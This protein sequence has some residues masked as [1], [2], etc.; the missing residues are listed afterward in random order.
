MAPVSTARIGAKI[1]VVPTAVAMEFSHE[2]LCL[3]PSTS[4]SVMCTLSV[5]ELYSVAVA[6]E[7][8]FARLGCASNILGV[9]S[10][11]S[12]VQEET[13][14]MTPHLLPDPNRFTKL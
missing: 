8:T 2:A 13:S 3:K 5:I 10:R 14:R 9:C 1:P 12:G 7:L 6:Q 4:P 11:T